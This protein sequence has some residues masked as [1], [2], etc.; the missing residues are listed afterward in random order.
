V[1]SPPARGRKDLMYKP[2]P[3]GEGGRRPDEVWIDVFF[4]GI[5]PRK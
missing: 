1:T 5:P 4:Q 2:S 3:E